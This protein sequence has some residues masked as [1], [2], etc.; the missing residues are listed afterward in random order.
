MEYNEQLDSIDKTLR[1]LID[2]LD[3][4]LKDIEK[5]LWDISAQ[6]EVKD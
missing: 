1:Q 2:I 4:R 5:T 3:R 6:I